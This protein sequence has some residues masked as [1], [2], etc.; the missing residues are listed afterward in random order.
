MDSDWTVQAPGGSHEVSLR[1]CSIFG[2]VIALSVASVACRL[3]RQPQEKSFQNASAN[4]HW[5]YP[6]REILGDTDIDAA[7]EPCR[8]VIFL[9]LV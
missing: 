3:S 1:R 2:P 9:G 8:T 7:D 4:R 5:Y 6:K